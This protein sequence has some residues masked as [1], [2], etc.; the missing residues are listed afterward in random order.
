M[1]VDLAEHE[2]AGEPEGLGRLD[3]SALDPE[4]RLAP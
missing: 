2:V 4:L 3:P 1:E